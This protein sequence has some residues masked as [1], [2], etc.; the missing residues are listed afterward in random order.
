MLLQTN[1]YVVPK[2]RRPEHSRLL[3]R[4][5]QTL[6]RLGCDHFEAYEQVGQNWS[7][8]ETSGRFVQIMRFRDRRHQLAVQAAERN[9]PQAQQLIA[10][11]CELIN[12]PY[13]QQH[14][15]FAVGFYTSALPVA[16]SRPGAVAA[17]PEEV[18]A[19]VEIASAEAIAAGAAAAEAAPADQQ[20]YVAH[21]AAPAEFSGEPVV[22]QD[23]EAQPEAPARANASDPA[24]ET[25]EFRQ[26]MDALGAE[27]EHESPVLEIE[28]SE[29]LAET[30]PQAP[31]A[32]ALHS[33]TN[34]EH[35]PGGNGSAPND[36]PMA[37]FDRLEDVEMPSDESP[38][39]EPFD[40]QLDDQLSSG[41]PESQGPDEH[42][43]ST[44]SGIGEVLDAGL[45]GDDELDVALPAELIE[46]ELSPHTRD[47]RESGGHV[48]DPE[49][50]R[51]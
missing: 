33:G 26:E 19:D 47:T 24:S 17:V 42:E 43:P 6:A 23:A 27:V 2:D 49:P 44:G 34:G 30:A 46:D 16:P 28:P 48:D 25:A 36:G 18:A 5:R 7:T 37:A 15:L 12:F 50:H 13:Q 32:E 31:S 21:A 29:A 1:S 40:T 20:T 3:R 14:G 4:F 10:E 41:H 51:A 11:F 9:D 39:H 35:T 22:P 45:M 38:A 8:G